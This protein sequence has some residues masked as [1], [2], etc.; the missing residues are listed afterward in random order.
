MLLV[1]FK[2]PIPGS[3]HFK[4]YVYK[5]VQSIFMDNLMRPNLNI[6]TEDDLFTVKHGT[7]K[8]LYVIP[9]RNMRK[10]PQK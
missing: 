3:D 9:M 4:T 10:T 1:T 8:N 6:K 5:N 7:Y 2:R